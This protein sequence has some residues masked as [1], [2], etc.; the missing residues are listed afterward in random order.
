MITTSM[1]ARFAPAPQAPKEPAESV[2][3]MV[4]ISAIQRDVHEANGKARL[5][6]FAVEQGLERTPANAAAV[7]QWLDEHVK[8]Y[9]SAAGVTAAVANLKRANVLTWAAPKTAPAP[10][11]PPEPVEVLADWQL[12]IDADEHMM[13]ASTTKALLDLNL[14]RRKLTN[15]MVVGRNRRGFG[16]SL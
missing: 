12:P 10:P 1:H 15:Q 7:Q 4:G 11:P 2:E 9:W 3:S 14:R 16:T 6:Q 13:K 5:E 8:G